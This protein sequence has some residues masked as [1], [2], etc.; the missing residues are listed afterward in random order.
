M[1][2]NIAPYYK[3]LCAYSRKKKYGITVD[4]LGEMLKLQDG[5]CSICKITLDEVFYV[6][7]CH[8][9]GKVRGVLCQDC[10]MGI[11]RLKDDPAILRSA[12][13]YLEQSSAKGA[14]HV[15]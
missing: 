15:A 14:S 4:Q 12:I 9:T 11:G 7:H 13:S 3:N 10:N 1:T 2:L 8:K 6:D 5:K